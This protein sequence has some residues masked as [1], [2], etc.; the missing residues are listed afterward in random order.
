MLKKSTN[1]IKIIFAIVV[2][3]VLTPNLLF[4]QSLKDSEKILNNL[5]KS[6]NKLKIEFNLQTNECAI[7]INPAIQTLYLIKGNK[8]L[9]SYPVSTSKYGIGSKSGSGKTPLGTHR[10][11]EKY[12]DGA[13]IGSTFKARINTGKIAKIFVDETDSPKDIVTTRI[14][15]LE[16]QEDGVNMNGSVDSYKRYIYI[17]GTPEEGLIGKPASHGCIRMRNTD[18][19]K[20]F[21][22]APLNTLVEIQNIK[23]QKE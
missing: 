2:I 21:N 3:G 7:I 13:K 9:A 17:H 18:V 10:V 8:I 15:R 5:Q 20:L 14:M 19:I 16:G 1:S 6:I 12:G 4:S 11:K 23:Y 22:S